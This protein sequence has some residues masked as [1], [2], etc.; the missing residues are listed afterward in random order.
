MSIFKDYFEQSEMRN[1]ETIYQG[2]QIYHKINEKAE[3][4]EIRIN[5]ETY[6][7]IS[8]V[9]RMRPFFMSIVSN[10]NHWLFI[11][12]NGGLSAGRK[13]SNFALFPYYTEDK[14]TESS[15]FTGSKSIFLVSKNDKTHLWEPFSKRQAGLYQIQRNLYKNA[16]GN[17]V[18]FEEINKDLGLSFSYEWNSS[19]A[20]GFV[21]KS[22]LS[23][24]S[25]QELEIRILD[26]IQNILPHGVEDGLQNSASNLVDAYRKCELEK[27]G[28]IGIYSLSAIIVDRAEPSEALKANIAWSIGL[29]G[30]TKL[31]SSLQLDDFRRGEI[32][33]EETDLRAE[34]GAYF[35]SKEIVLSPSSEEHW[36][37]IATVNHTVNQIVDLQKRLND[38]KRLLTEVNESIEEG[39]QELIKLVAASDGLQ[40]TQDKASYVRHFSNTMFNIMRGGIFDDNYTIEKPDFLKYFEKANRQLFHEKSHF[41]QSLPSVFDLNHLKEAISLEQDLD[42]KRLSIEYLPLKFSRRHGDPSRPWNKF[43]INTR[44][45]NDGSK[46]L[47]YQGNWRD[48]FQNWEALVHSYPAFIE[49]MIFKFLNATTFN[50]YNPYRV[51][52]DGFDWET[53]EPDNP[54]SY[55][56][57]WG[58]HQVIYLLKFLEFID[59]HYPEK[60]Q[61][62]F[63]SNLF[64]YANVPYKIKSYTE[65]LV[66][67]KNTI[68]YN[69]EEEKK[70]EI[71]RDK[72]GSDGTLFCDKYGSIYKVN[73][74]EKILAVVLSK[75]SNFIPEGGIWMN[76]QRPEWNDAN[77]ALVG[78]GVSMVTLY[79]LRRFLNFFGEALKDS[80]LTEIP[81]SNEQHTFFENVK[82][83]FESHQTELKSNMSDSQRKI[84]LDGL[85]TA[86]SEYRNTIYNNG[87]SGVKEPLKMDE[88][89]EFVSLAKV[90]LDHS[91][92]ANKRE[93]GMYHSY[94]LMTLKNNKAV[95]ISYLPEMLEGQVAVLSSGY[96]TTD[97]SLSVL[98]SLKASALFRDDQYSYILY[99]NK[100][101]PRFLAKNTIPKEHIEKSKLFCTLL[102][103]GNS[104][105]ITQDANGDYHFHGTF[106][107]AEFL[108]KALR[109]LPKKYLSLVE[110]ETNLVCDVYE[111]VF[112]HKAFTGRSGTFFGYEG[113]GSI[114]WHMVSKLL[115]ATFETIK[116]AIDNKYDEKIIGRLF[117]H[118]FEIKAGIGAHKSPT[119]YGAFS[120]DPYSHTPGGK[121]AQQPGMT[122]QVKEDILCRFGEMGICME[123]GRLGF[124]PAILHK[125]EFLKSK[126]TFEYYDVEQKKQE[127]EIPEN[128]L[129]LTICQVPVIYHRADSAR[130]EVFTK[131]GSSRKIEGN[132][133]DIELTQS[134]FNRTDDISKIHV[135]TLKS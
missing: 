4:S 8:Y 107:N 53:I 40:L 68:D 108:R 89:R 42:L 50:G 15:E 99:P 80:D 56:G 86:G 93:D 135:F 17:K 21:R 24:H 126:G 25:S 90:Y 2:E 76:T 133:L 49:G 43:S 106:N 6:Y 13:N 119:L 57:Y 67:P 88:L 1:L 73:F 34:R 129:A 105:I 65:I 55:I 23:N 35:L 127:L 81:I 78:N 22:K 26:G 109:A 59:K 98:D 5:N 75:L 33:Q 83:T 130:I 121:G 30:S 111:S 85:G 63:A 62:Y 92:E 60:L 104:K 38:P 18:I 96:L 64:V 77:N 116:K 20:F 70:I 95:S 101:L 123:N 44:D 19:N 79:Y 41:F 120:T 69:F 46:I 102:E 72:I 125:D 112:N 14:I 37:I 71:R 58:D 39:T 118:Y 131:N 9:D 94:N 61:T 87:F 124:D 103:D 7:K 91:I 100:D 54:W 48:I 28:N 110:K 45:E 10:S 51:T 97:Q 66:D 132:Y 128:A 16:Y 3:G 31:I 32:P 134:L 115:L 74:I 122:G 36:T 11:S 52:K 117:D 29:E 82:N 47:D 113:L 27:D 84:I 12:S 114:Y